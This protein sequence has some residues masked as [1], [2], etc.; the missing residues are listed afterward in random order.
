MVLVLFVLASMSALASAQ[1]LPPG[2]TEPTPLVP[3]DDQKSELLAGGLSFGLTAA[4]FTTL[5]VTASLAQPDDFGRRLKDKYKLPLYLTSGVLLA[6]GPTSGHIY[7][8][9]TW[10][11][12]LAVRLVSGT[13]MVLSVGAL[14]DCCSEGDHNGNEGA[15]VV[16]VVAGIVF[17]GASLYES[18]TAVRDVRR[19]N[20]RHRSP[21][22]AIAP[23]LTQDQQGLAVVGRF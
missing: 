22:I 11:R 14:D 9:T 20:A 12:G 23:M 2:A 5:L 6:V 17:L 21:S 10:N 18:A 8:G 19:Y 3:A 7:A 16:T 13:I 1:G 4:G 15:A